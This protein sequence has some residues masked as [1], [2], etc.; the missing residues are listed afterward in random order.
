MTRI[1]ESYQKLLVAVEAPAVLGRTGSRATDTLDH[2][3]LL[4]IQHHV[5]ANLVLPVV[6]EV[7]P[8]REGSPDAQPVGKSIGFPPRTA[9]ATVYHSV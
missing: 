2:E 1:A 9:C 4:L 7:V 8:V 3:R 5:E 6:A